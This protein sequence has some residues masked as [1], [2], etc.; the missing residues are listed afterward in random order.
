AG[1]V[2]LAAGV[3][4]AWPD[5]LRLTVAAAVAG[6]VLT[7]VAWRDARPWFQLGA[8]PALGLACV[9]AAHGAAGRWTPPDGTP[10]ADWARHLLASSSS[11]VTLT[12]LALLLAAAGQL[13]AGR[14]RR[15][16]GLGSALGGLGA[17]AVGLF[18]VTGHGRDE[19]WPAA[20]VY[21]A[22][23]TGLLAV[24]VWWRQRVVA[25]GGVSLGLLATLWVL[26]AG[27]PVEHG[28][29][30]LTV[31][32]EALALAG[33]ALALTPRTARPGPAGVVLGQFRAACRDV[34]AVAG[35]LAVGLVLFSPTFSAGRFHTG[36]FL[37]LAP[38][39]LLLARVS[40]HAAF[41]W[42]GSAAALA[43]LVRLTRVELD[44]QPGAAAVLPA[45][46]AHASAGVLLALAFRGRPDRQ[47]L[48]A[49]PLRASARLTSGLAALLLIFPPDGQAPAWAACAVWLAALW[50]GTV[51][52]WRETGAFSAA[53]AAL[54]VGA[55][56]A[57]LGWA[58]RQEWWT[59]TPL[60]VW[61]PRALRAFGLALGFLGLGWAAARRLARPS[62]RLRHLWLRDPFAVDRFV[63]G[64]VAV[65]QLFFLAV[66]V[67]P[68]VRAE[69]TPLGLV[70]WAAPPAFAHA[71][72]PAAWLL[73][74]LLAAVLVAKL[75]VRADDE[76]GGDPAL[77][78]LVV[79][80]LSGAVLWAGSFGPD[81]AAAS[82]LRWGLGA[83]FVA[84]SGVVFARGRLGELAGRGGFRLGATPLATTAAY[85][86]LAAAAVVVVLLTGNVAAL[87]LNRLTPT[88]PGAETAFAQ[89][90]WTVS[91]V[92]PMVLVV[93]GLAGTAV[94]ER[95]PG[96]ATAAGLAFTATL[97]G[98]YAL[99]VVTGGG[100]IGPAEQLRLAMLTAGG[101]AAW[102]AGWIAAERRVPG[103]PLLDYQA[104]VALFGVGLI[105]LVPLVH[106]FVFPGRPLAPEFAEFG[107]FGWPLLGFAAWAAYDRARRAAPELRAHVVGA[108][109]GVA[110]VLAACAVRPLDAPGAWVSFHALAAGWAVV[111]LALAAGVFRA[112]WLSRGGWLNAVAGALVLIALRGPAPGLGDWAGPVGL[113]GYALLVAGMAAVLTRRA[114]EE[115]TG[116]RR[117]VVALSAEGVVAVPAALLA[118]S[119]A[120]SGGAI[121][122]R[123]G[124]PLAVFL[125]A[126]AAGLL[127]G[128]APAGKAGHLRL[129]TVLLAAGGLTLVGWA[130]PDPDAAALWLRRNGWAFVA[131]VAAAVAC[132]GPGPRRLPLE[133]AAVLR[134]VGGGLAVASLAALVVVLIQQI[135]AFD[136][137]TR[138]T[139]LGL[140]AVLAVLAAILALTAL[141]LGAALRNA[142]DPLGPSPARRTGYVYLAQVLF[143]LLFV[144][145]RLNIPELFLGQLVQ[146]WT[147]LVML[148]AFVGVGAAE[149]FGRKGLT[150]LAGPLQQ[151]GVVLPLVP[152]LAFWAK[153]PG[154]VLA[155]ADDPPPG[156]GRSSATSKSYRST[157]TPTP[158]CGPSP[159]CCTD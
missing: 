10:P 77:V 48:F 26:Q 67:E 42:A 14:G 74:A 63:T 23:A 129:A 53:Q 35:V 130:A 52:A 18:L 91:N 111:G 133:W 17:G 143:V 125:L 44:L 82:A 146:Y 135:P 107:W 13:A 148:L 151:T 141:V 119:A 114:G 147:F 38:T 9:L 64:G 33:A 8:V 128:K 47:R 103:G 41:T 2:L 19:P 4:V 149:Y 118:V 139:P 110:G 83:A 70:P 89:L 117:W 100:V 37:A 25:L 36:T 3:T 105:A 134:R 75:R 108:A 158:G 153:P 71:F 142:T 45:L 73:P 104:G 127:A 92:A 81:L 61:D 155:F 43:G 154:P 156:C 137:A 109:G 24:N 55:V 66:W 32:L 27:R 131:L 69:Q 124:G 16:D 11:G 72:E 59:T 96:Y 1:A 112:P 120:V 50:F 39:G 79:L 46:L 68:G 21:L 54:A 87:G 101:V 29:W 86:L 31:A 102:A 30:G 62:L 84:G 113:A 28:A 95:L 98:G 106:V 80:L 132:L 150:V 5:P 78:G 157:S 76:P 90:G 144:H 123:L 65:G 121:L 97:A 159:A 94:R 122:E 51:W 22:A 138:R 49:D 34:A 136:P 40:G 20:G 12:G 57:G 58:E 140:P 115:S 7:R 145:V 93:V 152:L 99:A 60:G 85:V 88:G 126:T 6:A 116:D 15:A 56:L